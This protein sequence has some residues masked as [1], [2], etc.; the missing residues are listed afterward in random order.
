M[1]ISYEQ[2]QY[3]L[4][5]ALTYIWWKPPKRA[6]RYPKRLIAQIMTLG[7]EEEIDRL[8]S[9]FET[10]CLREVVTTA[11]IGQFDERSWARWNK[12]LG[13]AENGMPAMPVRI[14]EDPK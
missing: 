6:I 7:D 11:E 4:D 9:L 3:L 13:L 5:M 1:E 8:L 14:F 12:Y 2:R 10:D